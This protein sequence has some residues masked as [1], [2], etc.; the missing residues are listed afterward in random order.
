MLRL[1]QVEIFGFKSFAERT[2]I[3]FSGNG[4]AAIVGPNGCGKSNIADAILWVLGEQSAKTLRSGRMADCIFNGTATRPPTNLAEVTLTLYDPDSEKPAA[5]LPEPLAE[6]APDA[7]P[8]AG[9]TPAETHPEHKRRKRGLNLKILPGEVV[10]TRRLYRD[11]ISEY[12]LNGELCRLRDIQE[13]FMGTGLGPESYAI[14][15]QG[16]V[17]QILSSRPS[18]RRGLLEEAA[19]VTKYKT[20]RRLAE[21]K[22]ESAHQNLLRANDI[23]EEISK[24]LN[25]LKR[26]AARARRYQELKAEGT[27]LHRQLLATQLDALRAQAEA[28]A[29]QVEA[30]RAESERAAATLGAREQQ[31]AASQQRQYELEAALRV[32]QNRAGVVLVELERAQSRRTDTLR[33]QQETAARLEALVAQRQAMS[34]EALAA[35]AE[36]ER[37]QGEVARLEEQFAAAA[38]ELDTLEAEIA[39]LHRELA[40]LNGEPGAI[41]VTTSH[42]PEPLLR[43]HALRVQAD[44]L[45]A[46]AQR[47]LTTGEQKLKAQQRQMDEIRESLATA[48]AHEKALSELVAQRAAVAE[49]VQKL[50]LGAGGATTSTEFRAVGVVADF[51]ELEPDYAPLL[52]DYLHEE[53]EFVVV[54]TYDAARTGVSLLREQVGGRATFL[55]DSFGRFPPAVVPEGETPRG[56]DIVARVADLVR[57]NGALGAEAK[58]VLPRLSRTWLVGSARA[59]EELARR[60]PQYFF[61]ST[62]GSWYHGRL[63]SGGVRNGH[64]SHAM[65]RELEEATRQRSLLEPSV[66]AA[67]ARLAALEDLRRQL[68]ELLESARQALLAQ[69]KKLVQLQQQQDALAL[70]RAE[71]A[72][73]AEAASRLTASQQQQNDEEARLQAEQRRLAEELAAREADIVQAQQN[74]LEQ[75][76]RCQ[77]CET[78]LGALRQSLVDGEQALRELRSQLEA[79]RER[80]HQLEVEQAR[81]QSDRQHLEQTLQSEFGLTAEQLLSEV[82]ERLAGDTL[83]QAELRFREIKLRLENIGP[84]NMMALEEFQECEQ[85]HEFLTKQ[86]DDLLASIADTTNTIKE[87]DAESAKRFEEAFAVINRNFEETFKTLFGGGTATLRLTE[88]E[89]P[90]D[91]GIDLICQPPGKRLQNVLLLSGGEKALTALALLIAIFRYSPSPF[92]ILDEVDAPLDD[93]NVGRF[94]RLVQEMSAQTQFILVTHNKKTMEIAPVLYGVTMQGG[95]TQLVSVRFDEAPAAAASPAA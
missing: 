81:L 76:R 30:N 60:Y 39:R 55:V 43:A 40:P 82:T 44:E 88:A 45:V 52:E 41:R 24:Q 67:E 79:L 20:K 7:A 37:Q 2:R 47:A 51:T 59:A 8:E 29:A 68:A 31:Q 19:G 61:L 78:E 56:D 92:C 71:Q 62:D 50:L 93:T 17:G 72:R 85:R 58:R 5:P 70:A 94:T 73:L 12:Y 86:R 18:D 11:G 16:R 95:V 89:N 35:G 9:E 27:H 21:A 26:Q 74:K 90:A 48:A 53:L 83:A 46:A 6:A 14:I 66:R 13:L 64:G 49:P 32:E 69:E 65:R 15:E 28:L 22:L 91:A 38:A 63:V 34:N 84:V 42:M 1:R 23:L 77:E 54:E 87:I 10:V 33:Q 75:E 36:A 80:R 57:M 4:V 3:V 25:S